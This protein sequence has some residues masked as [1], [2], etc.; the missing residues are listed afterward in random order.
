LTFPLIPQPLPYRAAAKGSGFLPP[1]KSRIA[2]AILFTLILAGCAKEKE[3]E[4]EPVLNVKLEPV[5]SESIDR[6][7]PG[8]GILRAIDQSAIM[9]KIAAPVAKFY[10]NRG[11]HVTAGQLLAKLESRDLEA[12]VVDARGAYEQAAAT[13]R[14]IS[15]ATVPEEAVKAQADVEALRQSVEASKRL[16][17]SRQQLVRDGA[18]ARRSADEAAVLYAQAKSQYD[19]AL[20]HL[21]G[22]QKV[23]SLEEVKMAASA[24]ESAKGKLATT[25]AQL[26][27]AEIRS[28]VSGVIADR[29]IFQGEMAAPGT[30]LLTVMDVSSVIA[31]IN[32]PQ[33]QA[34]FVHIGQPAAITASD[35][36]AQAEGKVTVVSPAVDP[37]STTVEIWIQAANP[38]EKL[39]PGSTV[40]ASIKAGTVKDALVVPVSAL[41]PAGD[42]TTAVMV[43]G[44]DSVAKERK[45]QVPVRGP[46]KV[47]IVGDV[48][49]GEKVVV[50]GGVGLTDGAK[51]KVEDEKEE[52]EAGKKEDD[53]KEEKGGHE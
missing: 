31:R 50:D 42:G 12:A 2:L 8:E 49:P 47:Q 32:I 33:A 36:S 18:L 51:V 41:L 48:K 9:P 23:A 26:S 21:E 3:K 22:H 14:N 38:G 40:R 44:E 28:P 39:R 19:S 25:E 17:D 46:E 5:A 52:K 34:A 53:K 1:G 35:G 13:Y 43:V 4:T 20:K 29:P 37:Q 10:V 24:M 7:V 45:V 11:D 16:L 30:P 15:A 27:Y 6:I